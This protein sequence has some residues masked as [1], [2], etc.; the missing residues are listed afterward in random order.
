[1]SN[2]SD[3]RFFDRIYKIYRIENQS[4]NPVNPVNPVK[5]IRFVINSNFQV[6]YELVIRNAN[7]HYI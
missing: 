3:L 7:P 6:L 4:L 5:K 1:M 2:G